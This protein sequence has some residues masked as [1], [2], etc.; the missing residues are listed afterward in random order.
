MIP[1]VETLDTAITE[2]EIPSNTHKILYIKDRVSGHTD[3]LEAVKQAIYLILTTERYKF[4]IYDWYYGIQ[5][6]D[7]IGKQVTYVVPELERR[8]REALLEDDR[9]ISVDQFQFDVQKKVVTVTF[10]AT[11]N[12]GD[13]EVSQEVNY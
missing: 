6:I 7:L 4:P 2:V 5:L 11:T 10:V 3:G 13:V 1:S 9:I 8:I 12:V